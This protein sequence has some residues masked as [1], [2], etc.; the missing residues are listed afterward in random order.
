[1]K[2]DGK[3]VAVFLYRDRNGRKRIASG[4][5]GSKEGKQMYVNAMKQEFG[6]GYSETSD[7]ALMFIENLIGVDE[8]V[9]IMTPPSKVSKILKKDIYLL[10]ELP[11]SEWVSDNA[12]LFDFGITETHPIYPYL[13]LRKIGGVYHAKALLGKTGLNIV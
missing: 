6:R 5:D 8:L 7:R 12:W 13:Y 1:M 4:T 9:K 10:D 11:E 2:K 3:V